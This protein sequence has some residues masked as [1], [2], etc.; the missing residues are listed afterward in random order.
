MN[1]TVSVKMTICIVFSFRCTHLYDT[2][3]PRL[4]YEGNID[5]LCEL[6][7]IL[8]AEVLGEHLVLRGESV[9]G[10]RPILQRILADVHERLAFCARTHIRE[11]VLFQICLSVM[12]DIVFFRPAYFFALVPSTYLIIWF[13][14]YC[15]YSSLSLISCNAPSENF[16]MAL[17]N[18]I[19]I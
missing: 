16:I 17:Y 5:S 4:I 18:T 12:A 9:A 2:L 19:I 11:E 14:I 7:D 15:E 13:H 6:V 8:K 1:L 10:M 3:R